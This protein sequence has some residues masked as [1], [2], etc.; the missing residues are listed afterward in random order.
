MKLVI[1]LLVLLALALSIYAVV[2]ARKAE[3]YR[4]CSGQGWSCSDI[5]PC[6]SGCIC[7]GGY[8]N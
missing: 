4:Y 7:Y 1:V 2:K 8:C 5:K 6:P 3:P